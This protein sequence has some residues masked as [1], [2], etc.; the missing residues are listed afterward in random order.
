MRSLGPFSRLLVNISSTNWKTPIHCDNTEQSKG[1]KPYFKPY[2]KADL[3]WG[4]NLFW[5]AKKREQKCELWTFQAW[6][7]VQPMQTRRKWCEKS[8]CTATWNMC[9]FRLKDLFH[10]PSSLSARV[11][12]TLFQ[13]RMVRWATCSFLSKQSNQKLFNDSA[14]GT[15]NLQ[16]NVFFFNLFHFH[17]SE[18]DGSH[19]L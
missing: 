2:T 17:F 7:S 1:P 16:C 5:S 14:I 12:F 8:H 3:F 18:R 13:L 4:Y 10:M 6:R 9:K 19:P 15:C 11:P